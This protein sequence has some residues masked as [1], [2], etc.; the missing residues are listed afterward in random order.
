METSSLAHG[1]TRKRGISP[2]SRD[3]YTILRA[4]IHHNLGGPKTIAFRF[5]SVEKLFRYG[6][7]WQLNIISWVE[8]FPQV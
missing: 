1:G 8:T 5:V 7:S 2:I 3:I 4:E 6:D